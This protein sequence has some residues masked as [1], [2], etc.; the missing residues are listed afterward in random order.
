MSV[1]FEDLVG[2][3]LTSALLIGE[4]NDEIIFETESGK[5][6]KMFHDQE[7]CEC[8]Y[9]EDICGDLNDIVGN[10]ILM[11]YES[12][13]DADIGDDQRATWTFYHIAT[14][15]GSIVIRW[16]GKSNGY[17]SESVD[18]IDIT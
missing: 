4:H 15:K 9:I 17:Y 7:C 3:T 5:K 8:V 6:Y 12:S 13:S 11:A 1:L 14:I 16:C 2:E 18:F 10:K